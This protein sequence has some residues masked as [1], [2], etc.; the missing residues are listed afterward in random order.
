MHVDDDEPTP[1][2]SE[3]RRQRPYTPDPRRATRSASP[4]AAFRPADRL[5]WLLANAV[6]SPPSS[7]RHSSGARTASKIRRIGVNQTPSP[8]I[9][10]QYLQPQVESPSLSTGMSHNGRDA[11]ASQIARALLSRH[12]RRDGVSNRLSGCFSSH[13]PVLDWRLYLPVETFR[14]N[15]KNH[16]PKPTLNAKR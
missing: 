16:Q 5:S 13:V 8:S 4:A 14:R 12:R 11:D 15:P 1:P 6:L 2:R 3:L 9:S 7:R 10:G